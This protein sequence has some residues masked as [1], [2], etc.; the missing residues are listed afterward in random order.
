MGRDCQVP[1]PPLPPVPPRDVPRVGAHCALP[2]WS[3]YIET[4]L[5]NLTETADTD[6]SMEKMRMRARTLEF[7]RSQTTSRIKQDQE[8]LAAIEAALIVSA[9]GKPLYVDGWI[10]CALGGG[11]GRTPGD[12]C[13][14][15]ACSARRPGRF[16]W[17]VHATGDGRYTL[18]RVSEDFRLKTALWEACFDES[19][20]AQRLA[21]FAV[22]KRDWRQ[23]RMA[24]ARDS[25]VPMCSNLHAFGLQVA[26]DLGT[27]GVYKQCAMESG[28]P[29][30][31]LQT[32]G[33]QRTQ[34]RLL[35]APG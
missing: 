32:P 20:P 16:V 30:S 17:L 28:T 11:G 33:P 3:R 21:Y 10:G 19:E 34:C 24:F 31:G 22:H 23:F 1:P 27:C 2:G 18:R 15:Q 13:S 9:K 6:M 12:C 5:Y 7:Q 14:L 29:N 35:H 8:R 25:G 4:A 26:M